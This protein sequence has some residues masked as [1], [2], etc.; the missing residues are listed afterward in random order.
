MNGAVMNQFILYG[1][2]GCH[3]CDEAEALLLPLLSPECNIEY[4]DISESDTLVEQYGVLIPVLRHLRDDRELRWPFDS[5][6]AQLFLS[7]I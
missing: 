1:T 7:T 2:L 3:L 6:Q 5:A 4:V